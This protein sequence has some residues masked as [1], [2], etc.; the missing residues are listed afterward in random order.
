MKICRIAPLA[1][2]L[3]GGCVFTTENKEEGIDRSAPLATTEVAPSGNAIGNI[4]K[5]S[6]PE[7][8]SLG[9]K[10]KSEDLASLYEVKPVVKANP[11]T[12]A[13]APK[14][15]K[16]IKVGEEEIR[17]LDKN[18]GAVEDGAIETLRSQKKN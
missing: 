9:A 2:C 18:M 14:V 12:G 15:Y 11:S 7:L 17:V 4:S 10:I 1:L 8:D 6:V 3:L 13:P 5:G 16:M